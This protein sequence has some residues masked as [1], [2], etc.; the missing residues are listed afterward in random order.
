MI[1]RLTF[2]SAI[3]FVLTICSYYFARSLP[4]QMTSV[5]IVDLVLI[6]GM[7]NTFALVFLLAKAGLLDNVSSL[8]VRIVFWTVVMI[9]V[10]HNL[11]WTAMYMNRAFF[12]DVEIVS[13]DKTNPRRKVINQHM[14]SGVFGDNFRT[15]Q[16]YETPFFFRIIEEE[17]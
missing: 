8:A 4:I 6:F 12:R 9:A 13:I 14:D 3:A 5:A 11:F 2:L 7:L 15:V 1:K 17:R 10:L 16:V